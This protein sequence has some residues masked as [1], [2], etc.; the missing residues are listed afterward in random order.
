MLDTYG[1]KGV[2]AGSKCIE[3]TGQTGVR[4]DHLD[5]WWEGGLGQQRDNGG[6]LIEEG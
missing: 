1:Y 4:L 3:G 5:G 2:D 6:G